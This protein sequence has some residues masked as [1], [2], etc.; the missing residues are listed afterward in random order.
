MDEQMKAVTRAV[1]ET[2]C[3]AEHVQ[4]LA[5]Q[6]LLELEMTMMPEGA[7]ATPADSAGDLSCEE[8]AT[9]IY[10]THFATNWGIAPRKAQ[11][12]KSALAYVRGLKTVSRKN[13]KEARK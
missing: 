8:D 13:E 4:R 2:L 9:T 11:Q 5:S 6:T 12:G 10:S 1:T 7:V 3:E